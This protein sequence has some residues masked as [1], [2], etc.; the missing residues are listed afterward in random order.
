MTTISL[1]FATT[2]RRTFRT[3]TVFYRVARMSSATG[4]AFPHQT[5]KSH[6]E[7]SDIGKMKTEADGSFKRKAASFRNWITQDGEFTPE[8]GVLPFSKQVYALLT[9]L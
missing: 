7:Y 6:Q 1:R 2:A 5:A 9:P 8:K 3:S 4:S